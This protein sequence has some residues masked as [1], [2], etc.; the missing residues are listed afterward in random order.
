MGD[1][2]KTASSKTFSKQS[3]DQYSI[4]DWQEIATKSLRGQAPASLSHITANGLHIDPLYSDRPETIGKISP[5]PLQ[6]WD[7]RLAVLGDTA[8]AQNAFL[9][10]GL[11]GGNSS[12]QI[13]LDN[14][15]LKST[16]KI[17]QLSAVLENV[18]LDI[19]PI[20][21]I[22]GSHFAMAAE[23]ME[24]IWSRQNIDAVN[25]AASFNA[26]PIG[27]LASTGR[28]STVESVHQHEI[29]NAVEV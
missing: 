13:Q 27:T 28:L 9:L 16:I 29:G 14:P 8:V 20:S 3:F 5:S 2:P 19:V 6:R 26:D 11:R 12:A 17:E 18:Q 21:V 23:Q 24:S 15:E 4:E 7:N 1:R 22:A 25:A 10:T